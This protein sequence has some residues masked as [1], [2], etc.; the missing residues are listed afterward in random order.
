MFCVVLCTAEQLVQWNNVLVA[1][2]RT[3]KQFSNGSTQKKRFSP[4]THLAG[5]E[6]GK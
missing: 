1:V 2:A 4:G 6:S 5:P 3:S